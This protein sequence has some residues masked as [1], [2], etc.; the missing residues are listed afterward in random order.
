[1]NAPTSGFPLQWPDG[2]PRSKTRMKSSFTSHGERLTIAAAI[3][4]LRQQMDLLR[5]TGAVLSTNLELR[6]DGLPRSNQTEPVDPGVAVYFRLR[7]KATCM[8]CDRFNRVADNIAAI[9]HHID[10]VRRIERY[11]VASVEQMFTGFQAI[12]S[13][14]SKPWRETLGFKPEQTITLDMIKRRHRE[15]AQQI[16]PDV[17]GGIPGADAAMAEL[18]AARDMAL[19]LFKDI[20]Q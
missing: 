13:S 14:S 19:E 16:H 17:N 6:L 3:G 12:R 4:R 15:L 8:P 20:T 2:Y 1:M 11:G 7:G 5:A 9:A 18:N 10:A